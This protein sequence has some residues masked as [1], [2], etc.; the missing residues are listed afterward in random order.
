[1]KIVLA[2]D[3]SKFSEAAVHTIAKRARP[4]DTHVRVLHVVDP[5]SLLVAR[6]MGGYDPA[7]D[8]VWEAEKH[9]AEAL[10][11]TV[12]D[13]LRANG[14]KVSTV[15]EEG[16]PKSKIIDEAARWGADLIIVGSHGRKGLERF[17][18]GGVS[19]AV[20]RHARCSVEIVRI[21]PRS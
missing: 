10:V 2:I 19:D 18:L 15:V 6:E 12:A 16:D 13:E 8:A 11:A 14:F 7:L 20:A 3:G 17:L 5:P 4:E 21:P 1:M 9:Q